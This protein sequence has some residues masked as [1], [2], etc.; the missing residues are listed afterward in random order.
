MAQLY[1]CGIWTVKPGSEQQFVDAWSELA[2]WTGAEVAGSSWA[3]L[4]RDRERSNRF[5][6]FGPW[7]S[8]DA[9]ERWRAHPGWQE[10]VQRIRELLDSFEPNTLELA[11]EHG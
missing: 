9:I 3:K 6:S 7:D 8:L 5:I 4:L 10:R 1:A 2:E 11:A